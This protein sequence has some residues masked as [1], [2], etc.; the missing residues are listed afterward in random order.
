LGLTNVEFRPAS[1]T[2]WTEPATYDIVYGRFIL[3]HLA[4]RVAIVRRMCE[5]LRPGGVLILEDIDFTGASSYPINAA[6]ERYCQYYRAVIQ[7][8]GGD[9]DLGRQL[10]ELCIDAGL[11]EVEV[12]VVHP[13]HG[14]R[15]PEKALML[16]TLVNIGDAVVAEGIAT[17]ADVAE[18][19]AALTAFTEDPRSV[20][21][22]PRVFQV[23]GRWQAV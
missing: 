15:E 7:K 8:R 21:G 12:R 23:W 20:I 9:A 10:Y 17:A 22:L 3:S 13:A 6:Y 1:V 14:G 19:V 18:T 11:S 4:D 2:E 5:A 16:S